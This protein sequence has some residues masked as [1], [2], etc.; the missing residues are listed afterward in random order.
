M[1]R[2][3][4]PIVIVALVASIFAIKSRDTRIAVALIGSVP[5][6]G[7]LGFY[8]GC[9]ICYGVL[10]LQGRGES[11][12]D[13]ISLAG[14]GMLGMLVGAIVLPALAALLFKAKK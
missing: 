5:L 8:A 3:L 2:V 11:H 12:D 10:R 1:T 4:I 7:I 6:G 13:V 14:A 9:S